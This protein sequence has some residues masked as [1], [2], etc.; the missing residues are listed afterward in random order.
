[1]PR[2]Q[3]SGL[4][5]RVHAADLGRT[6][7]ERQDVA[8]VLAQG[9]GDHLRDAPFGAVGHAPRRRWQRWQPA[10]VEVCRHRIRAPRGADQRCL[11]EQARYRLAVEGR[12][13]DQDTQPRIQ[14]RAG[15]QGQRQSQACCRLRSWN[16]S[17]M[18]AATSSSA[19]SDPDS[20]VRIPSVITSMRVSR[21]TR[22]SSRMR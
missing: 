17:K 14:L 18:T 9:Q 21:E 20:R 11:P 22:V 4:Q 3:R 2:R 12:G 19:G 6:R 1:M 10:A 15:I 13:H 5:V 8:A 16:S 7:Q